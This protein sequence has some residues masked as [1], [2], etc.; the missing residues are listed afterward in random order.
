MDLQRCITEPAFVFKYLQI[1]YLY[2]KRKSYRLGQ[3]TTYGADTAT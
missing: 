2:V 1:L 3:T